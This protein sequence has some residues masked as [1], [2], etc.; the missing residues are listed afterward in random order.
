M[1]AAANQR[2]RPWEQLLDDIKSSKQQKREHAAEQRKYQQWVKKRKREYHRRYR[3]RVAHTGGLRESKDKSHD[4]APPPKAST[5]PTLTSLPALSLPEVSLRQKRY[6][7]KRRSQRIGPPPHSTA[8]LPP[9]S[10]DMTFAPVS[11]IPFDEPTV[12]PET[13]H[14]QDLSQRENEEMVARIMGFHL[15]VKGV[16]FTI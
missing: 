7:R 14:G 5:P 11:P 15:P 1:M 9:A 12:T 8:D 2:R 3:E 16:I 10:P 4:A 13:S 6:D